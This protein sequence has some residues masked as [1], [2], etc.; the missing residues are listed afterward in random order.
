MPTWLVFLL[1][2]LVGATLAGI[3]FLLDAGGRAA[4]SAED[5]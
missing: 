3:G 2:V 1:G 5:P 4:D